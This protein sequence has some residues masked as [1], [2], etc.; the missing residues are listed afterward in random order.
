LKQNSEQLEDLASLLDEKDQEI[1]SK[2]E[3]I[4][5]LSL[6]CSKCAQ[7]E[8][9]KQELVKWINE[10]SGEIGS[11]KEGSWKGDEEKVRLRG[12]IEGLKFKMD[13]LVQDYDKK[14]NELEQEMKIY[15]NEKREMIEEGKRMVKELE[16]NRE[17]IQ[18]F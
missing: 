11:S 18:L 16:T 14:L 9:E 6:K 12:E 13:H 17:M 1:R 15:S 2:S 4:S 10:L 3:L 7:H 8:F 5:E